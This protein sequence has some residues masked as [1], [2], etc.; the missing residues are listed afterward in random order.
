[1]QHKQQLGGNKYI[2][3]VRVFFAGLPYL[4]FYVKDPDATSKRSDKNDTANDDEILER[5]AQQSEG[6]NTT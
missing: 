5:M 6:L 3:N 2:D 1:M 4:V